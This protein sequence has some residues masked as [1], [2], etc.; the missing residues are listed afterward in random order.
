MMHAL[1]IS[2]SNRIITE[3]ALKKDPLDPRN[4]IQTRNG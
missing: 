4:C 2:L 1:D 3:R